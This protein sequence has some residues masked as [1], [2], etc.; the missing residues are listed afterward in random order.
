MQAIKILQIGI[1]PLGIKIAKMIQKRKGV[2]TVA[3]VDIHP[4][5]SGKDLGLLY[6]EAPSGVIITDDLTKAVLSTQPDI[7]VLT[8]VSD[9]QRI[10]PQLEAILQL[11]LPVVST[12]EELSYPWEEAPEAAT[13]IDTLARAAGVAVLGTGVN[14][15]FLMDAFPVFLTAVCQHVAHVRVNRYQDA[16]FRRIP[17]QKKIGAGLTLDQFEEKKQEGTLRHVGLTE[18][19]QMIARRM[20]WQLTKTE[21]IIAPIIAQKTIKTDAMTIAAGKA[22]GVEQ[23]GR[24]YIGDEVKI[25]LHFRAAVGEP[26]SFDEIMISGTPDLHSR[27]QG[28]VNGDIATGAMVINAIPRVLEATSGLKTMMD[29]CPVSFFF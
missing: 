8:T 20:A 9:M 14:P 27:I 29:I 2:E 15:G 11:G 3:A 24:G 28:G 18:S 6:G 12:C 4:N 25:E 7:V 1:G 5:L 10:A 21:D 13:K 17:F 26:E 22:T 23:I 16:Q 19:M